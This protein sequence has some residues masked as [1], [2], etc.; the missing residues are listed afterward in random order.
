MSFPTLNPPKTPLRPCAV[1]RA[2][3][4]IIARLKPQSQRHAH[5]RLW[6]IVVLP[7]SMIV[8][9]CLQWQCCLPQTKTSSMIVSWRPI[10]YRT[11][12]HLDMSIHNSTICI[13]SRLI[14]CNQCTIPQKIPIASPFTTVSSLWNLTYHSFFSSLLLDS[15]YTCHIL[16][17]K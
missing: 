8:Y 12:R 9:A 13:P 10:P 4:I 14:C 2:Y 6:A 5:A 7:P 1:I 16:A 17:N 3:R 11:W 15:S